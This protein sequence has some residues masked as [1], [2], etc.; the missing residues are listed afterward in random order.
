MALITSTYSGKQAHRPIC[1]L[2]ATTGILAIIGLMFRYME[3][4]G[5]TWALGGEI[6]LLGAIGVC[7]AVFAENL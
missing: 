3:N 4:P 7:F 2:Y 5:F 6:L 1:Y